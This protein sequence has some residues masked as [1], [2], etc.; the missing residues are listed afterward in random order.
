MNIPLRKGNRSGSASPVAIW[1]WGSFVL[2]VALVASLLPSHR[3]DRSSRDLLLYCAAG[4]REPVEQIVAEYRMEHGVTVHVQ[5]DGSNVLLSKIE[6][7]GE[8]DLYLAADNSYLAI[9]REKKLVEEVLPLAQMQAVVGVP[10]G[11]PRRL[12]SLDDLLRPGVRLVIPSPEQA[13]IGQATR[14]A[15][16]ATGRWEELEEHTRQFGVFRPTVGNAANDIKIGS[17]DA[18]FL[19]DAVVDQYDEIDIVRLPELE[20]AI[21]EIGLGVLASSKDPTAA[22]HFARYLAARDR[23]IPILEREGYEV[24]EGDTWA[25]QPQLTLYAGAVTRNALEPVVQAFAEREGAKVTTVYNGCGILTAQM[26][27]LTAEQSGDF[28]DAFMACDNYYMREVSDLFGS[29]AEVSS[30]PIVIAT[31]HGNPKNIQRLSDLTNPDVKVVLGQPE[32][33]TIGVLS[34]RLLEAE[35]ITKTALAGNLVAEMPTSAMLVPSIT[36]GAADVALVYATDAQAERDRLE[37]VEIDSPFA[38]AI[39]PF[40]IADSSDH[41]LLGKR[42]LESIAQSRDQF[43]SAG[44]EWRLAPSAGE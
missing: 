9:A 42:L 35:G 31:A 36:T 13:A 14:D 30:A 43:E 20:G 1:F 4:L 10:G 28:P 27:S 41:K 34:R 6:V 19:W 21:G 25:S 22:L 16:K 38:R 23:G 33:C 37:V 7:S 17:V 29:S 32:Q 11:N 2:F 39:Q 12:E 3:R 40:G 15:L 24:V 26:R 8:G 44:F 18:G 5:Y